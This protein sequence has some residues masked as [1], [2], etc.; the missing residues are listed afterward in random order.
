MYL[1]LKGI[2]R[3]ASASSFRNFVVISSLLHHFRSGLLSY[4]TRHSHSSSLGG[5]ITPFVGWFGIQLS[6]RTLIFD[7]SPTL[8]QHPFNKIGLAAMILF[9]TYEEASGSEASKKWQRGKY[10]T[11]KHLD[12]SDSCFCVSR[13]PCFAN[14]ARLNVLRS[15]NLIP[16]TLLASVSLLQLF[17]WISL[18]LPTC[19]HQNLAHIVSSSSHSFLG[20]WNTPHGICRNRLSNCLHQH[21]PR[22]T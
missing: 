20:S 3:T 5:W 17:Q 16:P 12:I 7:P 4:E 15:R 14:M 1:W 21:L 8:Q 11:L 10:L 22:S 19:P 2:L 9:H 6:D 18:S 13:H